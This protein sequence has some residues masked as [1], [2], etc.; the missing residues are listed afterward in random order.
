MST[1][2]KAS[3]RE[4]MPETWPVE[5]VDGEPIF[6]EKVRGD[7]RAGGVVRA[8]EVLADVQAAV[9]EHL[10]RAYENLDH[11]GVRHT[12]AFTVEHVGAS[13]RDLRTAAALYWMERNEA[14]EVSEWPYTGITYRVE[15]S[16]EAPPQ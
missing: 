13:K 4:G 7:L 8:L 15:A 9:F 3:E 5:T 12:V 14:V 2:T 10:E 1:A 6:S 16:D 11:D